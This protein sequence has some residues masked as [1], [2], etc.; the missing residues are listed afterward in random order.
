MN[1]ESIDASWRKTVMLASNESLARDWYSY[2]Q[3][4]CKEKGLASCHT[5]VAIVQCFN[6]WNDIMRVKLLKLNW[7]KSVTKIE[8]V[9]FQW[10]HVAN[11]DWEIIIVDDYTPINKGNYFANDKEGIKY[12]IKDLKS[13]IDYHT[14]AMMKYQ[15]LLE[16]IE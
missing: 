15:S 9:Y 1:G 11:I 6:F 13:S 14:D 10:K 16:S 4:K 2:E 5:F 8:A 3:H 12:L 7:Y